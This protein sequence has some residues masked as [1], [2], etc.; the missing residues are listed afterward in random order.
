LVKKVKGRVGNSLPSSY[1]KDMKETK[2]QTTYFKKSQLCHFLYGRP[3]DFLD[4]FSEAPSIIHNDEILIPTSYALDLFADNIIYENGR[5]D[6]GKSLSELLNE[7][8]KLDR[9]IL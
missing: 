9:I 1:I 2:D 3:D 4:V 8:L 6:N 7:D 5:T